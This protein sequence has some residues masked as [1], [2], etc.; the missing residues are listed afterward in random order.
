MPAASLAAD[1]TPAIAA[2]A[3]TAPATAVRR[4]RRRITALLAIVFLAVAAAGCMPPEE[5]T[6]FDRTNA[7]RASK[8]LPALSENQT[9]VDKA[10]AW[11]HVMASSGQ[12]KHSNLAD[13]L[14]GLQWMVLGEN[15]GVTSPG[16]DSLLKLHQAL[17]AS[18]AHYANLVDPRFTHMGVGVATS[19]DGKVWVVEIFAKL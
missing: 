9:L 4:H 19:P 11:A 15:V 8:G 3:A 14:G 17:V 2:P 7:L 16:G 10:E 18:P 1:S 6:F 12:L 5:T 13:G